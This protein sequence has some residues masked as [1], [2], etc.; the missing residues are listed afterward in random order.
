[1]IQHSFGKYLLIA[2]LCQ[3]NNSVGSAFR[4]RSAQNLSS[5][6]TGIAPTGSRQP[7][8]ACC[9]SLVS[10]LPLLSLFRL[11]SVQQPK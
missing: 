6:T 5:L 11:F 8:S 4:H 7:S 9:P 10:Q 1:M 3:Q 2:Y